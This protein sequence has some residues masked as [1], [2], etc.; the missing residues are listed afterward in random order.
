MWRTFFKAVLIFSIILV[1]AFCGFGFTMDQHSYTTNGNTFAISQE[2]MWQKLTK[3]KEYPNWRRNIKSVD[4][5]DGA[6]FSYWEEK[7]HLGFKKNWVFA[8]NKA[9]NKLSVKTPDSQKCCSIKK[10]YEIRE[11][12]NHNC[13]LIITQETSVENI[14][15]RAWINIIGIDRYVKN[16]L[17]DLETTI[18]I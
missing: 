9:Y 6:D 15:I 11:Q 16:E 7:N 12:G 5:F 13:Y 14:F 4:R 3:V 17:L 1:L 8:E 18:N 2:D 10:S